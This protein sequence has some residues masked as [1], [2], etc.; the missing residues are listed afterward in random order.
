MQTYR[1]SCK[2][3]TQEIKMLKVLKQ[4]MTAYK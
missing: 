2:K 1:V 4:K 3:Y